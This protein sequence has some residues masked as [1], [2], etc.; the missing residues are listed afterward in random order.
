MQLLDG[1][2][3]SNEIMENVKQEVSSLGNSPGLAVILIGEDKASKIYVN[4]KSK[5]CKEVGMESYKYELSEDTSE[6]EVLKLIEELNKDEKVNGILVQ[7]PVPSHISRNKIMNAVVPSKDVDGFH[8]SNIGKLILGEEGLFPC[9]AIGVIKLLEHYNIELSGKE[10]VVIGNSIIVGNPTAQLLL[11][12]GA[13]V[14]VCHSKTKDLKAHTEKADIIV[15]AAGKRNLV[16]SDMV[17]QG[18]VIVDV[19][20]VREQGKI[21][22]DVDFENV[23]DKCSYITPVPGGAGPMTVACLLENTLKAYKIQGGE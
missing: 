2:K 18:A 6:E 9:T 10:A 19:G 22:G 4:I 5:K 21:Y 8:P 14:T 16:T 23:K 11:K 12:K 20:I 1:E 3:V 17:K 15:S 7:M 13:T